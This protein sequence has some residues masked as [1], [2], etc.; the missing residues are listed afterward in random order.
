MPGSIKDSRSGD[1][2]FSSSTNAS[3]K[4]VNITE[5]GALVVNGVPEDERS[6]PP[7][8]GKF[9]PINWLGSSYSGADIKVVAHLYG[10][11]KTEEIEAKLSE[12]LGKASE[13]RD[14]YKALVGSEWTVVSVLSDSSKLSTYVSGLCP[15]FPENQRMIR[16]FILHFQNSIGARRLAEAAQSNASFQE[17]VVIELQDRLKKIR[18]IREK[19][20][21]VLT[22]A[23]LQTLSV[24]TFRQKEPVVA[25]G[26]ANVKG[27]T[28]GQR[29]IAGS[30]IFTLFNEHSLAEL[31]R[32]LGGLR[33]KY[34][35]LDTDLSAVLG[36]QLP[37]LD[38][39]IV[40]ANE[41][42]SLS[43]AAIYGVEFVSSGI[44]M[45]IEDIISEE[46]VQFV[47]RDIDPMISQG[48]I[49]LS[50]D[51]RGMHFNSDYSRDTTG[52][53]LMF[54]SKDS[55]NEFL[56]KIRMRRRL[57]NR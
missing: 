33:S 17:S 56:D 24:Q 13:L 39:T 22:L 43:R 8:D 51:Q 23:S 26:T 42:G 57:I 9:S 5:G 55:Y 50:R 31:C 10:V 21:T 25:L 15:E 12:D 6:L 36:D 29:T 4:T 3:D 11:T 2:P 16:S 53:D 44:T 28:R 41:Y 46:V 49:G 38:L 34:G 45:S 7:E 18:D 1:E 19:S 14:A 48:N 47:A 27:Y 35:E 20:S 40:F 54:S 30:M 37:P 52:T 32:A